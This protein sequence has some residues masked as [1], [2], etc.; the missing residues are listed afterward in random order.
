[1]IRKTEALIEVD[2]KNLTKTVLEIPKFFV[3]G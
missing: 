2:S 3:K 1:M